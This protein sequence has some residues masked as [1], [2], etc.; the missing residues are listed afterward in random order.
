MGL[1][2]GTIDGYINTADLLE[3][4]QS[5]PDGGKA[6]IQRGRWKLHGNDDLS[7]PG[8]SV[9]IEGQDGPDNCQL[10]TEGSNYL[11]WKKSKSIIHTGITFESSKPTTETHA[12]RFG[13]SFT[14]VNEDLLLFDCV[15]NDYGCS[16]NGSG[17]IWTRGTHNG[18]I[19]SSKFKAY[20]TRLGDHY[21]IQNDGH[22]KYYR[23]TAQFLDPLT[24]WKYF[25]T[26]EDCEFIYCRHASASDRGALCLFR[27]NIVHHNQVGQ[28]V[29]AHGGNGTTSYSTTLLIVCNN[30]I[31]DPISGKEKAIDYRGGQGFVHNNEI[32]GYVNGVEF[33]IEPNLNS[34]E[35]AMQCLLHDTYVWDLTGNT[36]VAVYGCPGAYACGHL[37][38]DANELIRKDHEYFLYAPPSSIYTPFGEHPLRNGNPDPLKGD[39]N[40]DGVVNT[41]DISALEKLIADGE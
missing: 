20:E 19:H 4:I 9:T 11:L 2:S 1:V 13:T 18:L 23:N 3:E 37:G 34:V 28:A 10:T 38:L 30:K 15:F 40:E 26:I 36:R 24:W 5:L 32:D 8:K 22:N 17:A 6:T 16:S 7:A 39:I 14:D 25:L 31:Y 35:I 29:D 21:G 12:I 41:A 33:C 27:N